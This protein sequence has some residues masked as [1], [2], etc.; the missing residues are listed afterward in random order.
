MSPATGWRLRVD[1]TTRYRY[2]TP[3]RASY[4]EVRVIPR[5]DRRQST[6]EALVT[7]R[8]TTQPF[9]Y[10]DYWGTEVVAFDVAAAHGELEIRGSAVVETQPPAARARGSWSDLAAAADRWAELLAPSRHTG[11]DQ[12]LRTA[13]AELRQPDPLATVEAVA[14][15]VHHSLR[16]VPGTTGVHT[17]GVD[18]WRAGAGVCQDFAHL[19][20]AATRALG[21]P[22]RY[23]SGYIHPDPAAEE[24]VEVL[25]ES[26]AWLEV[27]T[28]G[29]WGLDP[30]NAVAVGPRHVAVA[31]GRDYA[32][33]P[34]VRG[35]FAGEVEDRMEV[36]VRVTRLW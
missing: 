18:A 32:D 4:N 9:R 16:Y 29:W 21:V 5:T 25:G 22:S 23:V 30:T 28:G 34:P 8:P 2:S 35:V 19:T 6:L 31:H 1:H 14:D 27:W 7:T 33:V 15:W 26:H 24:R 20:L 17:A 10:R 36:E 11:A 3:V 13:V 12:E